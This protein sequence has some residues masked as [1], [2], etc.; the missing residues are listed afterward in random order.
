MHLSLVNMMIDIHVV[1]HFI[2]VR[3]DVAA[4]SAGQIAK[5]RAMMSRLNSSSSPP[6]LLRSTNAAQERNHV[7]FVVLDGVSQGGYARKTEGG[8]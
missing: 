2:N 3:V 7:G 6:K 8:A 1:V 4:P 5:H